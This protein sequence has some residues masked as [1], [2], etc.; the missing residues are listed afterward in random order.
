MDFNCF[1]CESSFTTSKQAVNHLKRD[2]FM[3]A[4]SEPI[5]CIVKCCEKSFNTFGGLNNHLKIFDHSKFVNVFHCL[6]INIV[7]RIFVDFQYPF[8]FQ[9]KSAEESITQQI[10]TIS[11]RDQQNGPHFSEVHKKVH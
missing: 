9:V 6:F 8:C 10:E 1:K 7:Q 11:L 5:K 4:N 2:H 3:V